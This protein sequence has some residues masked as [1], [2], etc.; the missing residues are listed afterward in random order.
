M[1][2]QRYQRTHIYLCGDSARSFWW[3]GSF[4]FQLQQNE[5][6]ITMETRQMGN[7]R[8]KGNIEL[9][10]CN[11]DMKPRIHHRANPSGKPAKESDRAYDK[12]EKIMMVL[13]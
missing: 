12:R 3:M 7:W 13:V 4:A 6:Q 9:N 11:C 10:K 2:M 8:K 1:A 5:M